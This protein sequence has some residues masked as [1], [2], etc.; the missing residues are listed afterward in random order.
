MAARGSNSIRIAHAS[1]Y[2]RMTSLSDTIQPASND[3]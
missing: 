3:S 1:Y 2:N